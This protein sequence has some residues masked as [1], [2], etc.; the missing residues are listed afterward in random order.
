MEEEKMVVL[1]MLEEGKITAEE[2]AKLL[3]AL[4]GS[5][6]PYEKGYRKGDLQE[7]WKEKI[8]KMDILS[9]ISE[10]VEKG[11]EEIDKKVE[12]IV[13]KDWGSSVVEKILNFFVDV[14]SQKFEKEFEFKNVGE[15][16]SL[17]VKVSN[18]K[19]TVEGW[20][21]DHIYVDVKCTAKSKGDGEIYVNYNEGLLEVK[22]S[23][24]VR[25][26]EIE[27]YLPFIKYKDIR[28][29]VV[30]GR[31]VIEDIESKNLVLE[32][33]NGIIVLENVAFEVGEFSTVNGRI[34]LEDL[35]VNPGNSM[36][37]AEVTNGVINIELGG[38]D[39]EVSYEL[40]ATAGKC[41]VDLTEAMHEMKKWNY[42]KG[43]TRNY[44]KGAKN[45]EVHAR[46]L[47]DRKS[48]V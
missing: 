20:E 13:Q 37:K 47:R 38:E 2:A 8:K 34:S 46:V 39:I 14:G 44:G 11:L 16:T 48:V 29:E 25:S 27:I 35:K 3:D 40:E 32:T 15:N 43:S 26:S 41:N 31:I 33:V 23:T 42:L 7:K 1:K 30:N 24:E 17:D 6:S 18:G 10:E 28:L 22:E 19:V 4:E 9:G 36:L 21:E 45:L 5:R 12:K